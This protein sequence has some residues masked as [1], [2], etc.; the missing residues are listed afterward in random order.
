MLTL[1]NSFIQDPHVVYER[2]RRQGPAEPVLMW[3]GARVWMVTRYEEARALLADPRLKKDGPTAT[4]LL[5]P[6]LDRSIGS[7]LGDNMLFKDPPDHTRLRRFVS[8][9]FTTHSVKRLRPAIVRIADDLLDDIDLQGDVDLMRAYAQPLPVRVIGELLGVPPGAQDAFMSLVVPIFTS[10]DQ[11]ELRTARTGLTA[12]LRT[13]VA[14][15][16]SAPH[17]DVLSSLV[18]QRDNG[19]RLSEG[20]LLGTAFLLI[21][22]GYDTT[23][24]LIG[25]G[26]LTLLRN[27]DQ[28]RAVRA[29]RTL[30]PVAVEEILR[31]E[32]PLNTAT[33]RLTSEPIP[34]GDIVIPA[35]EVVL[36]G[37]L[38]ANRDE[39]RFADPHLFDVSR[40]D[41]RHLAFGHGIHHCLGAPLARMEG[42]IA[43]DRMLS[44]YDDI[45]LAS[46]SSLTYRPSTLMR[47]LQELPV[48]VRA[49]NPR[50]VTDADRGQMMGMVTGL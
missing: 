45:R 2:L 31:Y 38:G 27:P 20:E 29:D 22:A 17:G 10:T 13:I 4:R 42:E 5:P 48:T 8:A 25:N 39:L 14:A 33:V 32:S 21:I 23:V 47:G 24:N 7:V 6:H 15:K 26:V 11:D 16:R 41:N 40:P 50:P 9:A 34:L 18:H 44:R 35:N 1:D 36:I 30:L 12:L 28:L 19:D 37:L 46:T 3:G 43:L 49:T